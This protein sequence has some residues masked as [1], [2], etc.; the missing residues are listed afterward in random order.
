MIIIIM[1]RKRRE[2]APSSHH[3]SPHTTHEHLLH[4][5]SLPILVH[6]VINV[7]NAIEMIVS[8]IRRP[9]ISIVSVTRGGQ[10]AVLSSIWLMRVGRKRS[11]SGGTSPSSDTESTTTS[12]TF[13][14]ADAAVT[15][16]TTT[17]S[18]TQTSSMTLPRY[19]DD[20][21]LHAALQA[22]LEKGTT[23]SQKPY[24]EL[25]PIQ[26]QMWHPALQGDD[27]VAI[28][29]TGTGKT[30]A[31][32]LP[33]LQRL[34]VEMESSSS[35]FIT[36]VTVTATEENENINNND[37]LSTADNLLP[38]VLVIAPTREL[39]Q[40]SA[41]TARQLLGKDSAVAWHGGI[42]KKRDIHQ[43]QNMLLQQ[44]RRPNQG[45]PFVLV[46]TPG[47][48]LDHIEATKS[49]I[50]DDYNKEEN[51]EN[52]LFDR[53]NLQEMSVRQ[54]ILQTTRTLV[55]DEMDTLLNM[56]FRN[57]I[58]R[59]LGYLPVERQTILVS[60]TTSSDI[61]SMM[62]KCVRSDS[63]HVVTI[64]CLKQTHN[65][66]AID[67]DSHDHSS[68]PQSYVILPTNEIVWRIVQI[69]VYLG[70]SSHCKAVV[71]FPTT[72]QVRFFALLV[73]HG[74]GIGHVIEM[75]GQLS[76]GRRSV[77]SD[78]FR[79]LS[80]GVLLTTD[81]SARG[82]D[83][84]N[85]T[86]VVQVG[87]PSNV[88]TYVH[89][90]GRTGRAG[91][92]QPGQGILLLTAAERPFLDQDLADKNVV[93]HN[94]W[95]G[96]VER[97]IFPDLEN[98]RLQLV[99]RVKTG[100]WPELVDL[101]QQMYEALLGYYSSQ[102]R[103]YSSSLQKNDTSWQDQ[104]VDAAIEYCQQAGLVEAPSLSRS[105]AAQLGLEDNPRVV[106]RERWE[107]G[108]TFDVGVPSKVEDDPL[109][110]PKDLKRPRRR[111]QQRDR[112][113]NSSGLWDDEFDT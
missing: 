35:E 88:E 75:H 68:I 23:H 10:S 54:F 67:T 51:E 6:H 93:L 2:N 70:R 14:A 69:I 78:R 8:R 3:I 111:S 56:G 66:N 92:E 41:A 16:T 89:R 39:A 38:V 13:P 95:Q 47:R 50:I 76:Q 1:L 29:P 108:R 80:K 26:A 52:L 57:P 36:T 48:L 33:T 60:A 90:L 94:T 12:N 11:W 32:L 83:Y 91:G 85:V 59:I 98:V 44:H 84:P 40:Q 61:E 30:L 87:V 42:S 103:R 20:L 107:S 100:N 24:H 49:L 86:H 4:P 82:M 37:S 55:L 79:A 112:L 97:R 53:Y 45:M 19:F 7:I 28:A 62:R 81:V 21:K 9:L 65:G 110:W 27:V 31:F 64:D 105:T 15:S 102:L 99:H 96:M 72:A 71:F 46:T 113:T 18:D 101:V 77:V 22:A 43:L 74:L 5:Q 25:T 109:M 58:R 106:L 34:L 104:V 17:A 63:N 73:Q